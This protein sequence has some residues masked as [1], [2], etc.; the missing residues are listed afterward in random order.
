M[1]L[2]S[3]L[4]THLSMFDYGQMPKF[5]ARCP[6]GVICQTKYSIERIDMADIFFGSHWL[7]VMT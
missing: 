7:G 1:P 4:S 3:P 6:F 2:P 5:V